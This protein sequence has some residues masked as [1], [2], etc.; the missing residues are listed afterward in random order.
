MT[1]RTGKHGSRTFKASEIVHLTKHPFSMTAGKPSNPKRPPA[2]GEK[3]SLG[4]L[5]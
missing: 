5:V 3:R 4:S 1:V 2:R